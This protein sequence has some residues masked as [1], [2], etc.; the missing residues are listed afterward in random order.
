VT[1]PLPVAED[2]NPLPILGDVHEVEVDAEGAGDDP[3]LVLVEPL[4]PGGQLPFGVVGPGP[5]LAGEGPHLLDERQ[6]LRPLQVA[7]H[8]V[9]QAAQKPHVAAKQ[10]VFRHGR[11]VSRSD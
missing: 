10:I 2:A 11:L 7:D 5:S 3:G 8:V 6:G 1:R 4:D 9:E